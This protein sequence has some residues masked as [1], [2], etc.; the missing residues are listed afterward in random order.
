MHPCLDCGRPVH[1]RSI[2]CR[3]CCKIVR[4]KNAKG[5]KVNRVMPASDTEIVLRHQAWLQTNGKLS[6]CPCGNLF[7]PNH[8]GKCVLCHSGL[9]RKGKRMATMKY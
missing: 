1:D 9:E 4:A 6:V 2:R 5:K 7:R 3:E 8:Q